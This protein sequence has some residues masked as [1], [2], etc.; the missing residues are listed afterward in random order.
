MA[1]RPRH[2]G[3]HDENAA[4]TI[5]EGRSAGTFGISRDIT[6]QQLAEAAL[7]A[8]ELQYRTLYDSS[9]D[10]IMMLDPERGFPQREPGRDPTVRLPRRGRSSSTFT[11]A[12]SLPRAPAGR[13]SPR[14]SKPRQMMAI[15]LDGGVA[16][17]RVAAPDDRWLSSSAL[18]AA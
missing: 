8:S 2:L 1:G 9:R 10:A 14:R 6:Q 11:P 5:A 18:G 7:R 12:D 4:S 13:H 15:A 16:F 3:Q 17:L